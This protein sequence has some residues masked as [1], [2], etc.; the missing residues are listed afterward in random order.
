MA[1][2]GV[3]VL[4][5]ATSTVCLRSWYLLP[6]RV[7]GNWSKLRDCLDVPLNVCYSFHS[8][9]V[10][11]LFSS[12]SAGTERSTIILWIMSFRGVIP[13][14]FDRFRFSTSEEL[15]HSG[16]VSAFELSSLVSVCVSNTSLADLR[17]LVLSRTFSW[18]PRM[19][20][21]VL[22]TLPWLGSSKDLR[23]TWKTVVGGWLMRLDSLCHLPLP[24]L[25]E[26]PRRRSIRRLSSI[27]FR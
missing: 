5:S 10:F 24:R 7:P 16:I 2:H 6:L 19:R 12:G 15:F 8:V 20:V 23:L 1:W 14:Y 11:I 3:G 4:S 17:P 9:V 13:F 18:S 27:N 22:R 21:C 26:L 25:W